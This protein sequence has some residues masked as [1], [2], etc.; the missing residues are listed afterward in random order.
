MPQLMTAR[1]VQPGP[2]PRGRQDLIHSPGRQRL[3]AARSLEGHEDP[4]AA[5]TGRPLSVQ[6]GGHRGEEPARDRD[7]PLPPRLAL[8][9][10][11][12]PLSDVQV[13]QAQPQDLA[14]AQPAE[15][16]R[17]DHGPVPVRAQCRG[18]RI[19][20]G[21]RQDP[22]QS[23]GSAHQR[24]TLP[25]TRP[26]PPGRQPPRHRISRHVTAGLQER[27]EARH[28]R[29]PPPDRGTSHPGGLQPGIHRL[30]CAVLA[31]PARA[32]SG[33]ERQ[34][35]GRP[36]LIGRLG[37]HREEHLQVIRGRQHRVRPAPPTQ[38][39]QVDIGQRHADPDN[40]LTGR[41][42]RTG[43][44]KAGSRHSNSSQRHRRLN[45]SRV[46]EMTRKITCITCM[47]VRWTHGQQV[48]W[49]TAWTSLLSRSA[50]RWHASSV[51]M[52]VRSTCRRPASLV[53]SGMIGSEP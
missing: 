1:V 32:L 3:P 48:T 4:V 5:G 14:A 25:G 39:L 26:F 43:H 6:V 51:G 24:D 37:N 30:Q 10:E 13:L 16:H 42:T 23:P 21:R 11:H 49:S 2:A 53:T 20:L 18:Q 19:H 8:D 38:E 50:I 12:P 40:Q 36:D 34:H 29:Q 31:G 28:D 9:D 22:R 27:E 17:R 52:A 46:A 33:D 15:D 47:R 44:A 45:P 41:L 7:Q 35:I